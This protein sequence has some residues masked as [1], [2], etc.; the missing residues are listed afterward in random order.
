MFPF[1]IQLVGLTELGHFDHSDARNSNFKI[2]EK[3][4]TRVTYLHTKVRV[5]GLFDN[6][7]NFSVCAPCLK[8]LPCSQFHIQ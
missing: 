8:D 2:V 1:L 5:F 3:A 7:W 6:V 4:L